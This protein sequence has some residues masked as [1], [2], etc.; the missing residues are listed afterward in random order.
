MGQ[1]ETVFMISQHALAAKLP[2]QAQ[3]P[4]RVGAPRHQITHE[5]HLFIGRRADLV[6]ELS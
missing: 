2:G 1:K 3:H 4:W 5:D 6:Q